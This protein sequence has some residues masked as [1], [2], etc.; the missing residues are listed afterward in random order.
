MTDG[1]DMTITELRD[2]TDSERAAVATAQLER[3]V[4][5]ELE[6]RRGHPATAG[7]LARPLGLGTVAVRDT[8]ERHL[9]ALS[10]PWTALER[11]TGR[12]KAGDRWGLR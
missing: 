2:M 10:G 4:L 6:R 7:E 11:T 9:G 12:T 5:A 3:L 8:L 1:L